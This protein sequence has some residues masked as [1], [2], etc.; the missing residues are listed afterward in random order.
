MIAPT[1]A[2][3]Q[4]IVRRESRSLL[5]YVGDAYP[6]TAARGEAALGALKA[7]IQDEAAAVTA[8]GRYLVRR[9]ITPEPPGSY[10]TSFTTLNF[11]GFDYLLP[12]LV[13]SQRQL[14]GALGR[15]LAAITDPDAR[16]EVEKLVA[17]KRRHLA[18]L[19][20][21]AAGQSQSTAK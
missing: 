11:I 1:E 4:E 10:P 2:L 14:L 21:L 9:H 3:L 6:W 19:G 7:L 17:V 8:L 12:R 18:E 20:A 16:G 5:M 15:D 13:E